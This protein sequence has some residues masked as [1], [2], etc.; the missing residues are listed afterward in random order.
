MP[1]SVVI[2]KD[3]AEYQPKIVGGLT[4]RTLVCIIG[5]LGVSILAGVYLY[6]VLGLNVADNAWL[7]YMVSLPFWLCG[8]IKPKGM[9]FEEFAS[10]W[11]RHQ[12]ADGRLPYIP[13]MI[14]IGYVEKRTRKKVQKYDSIYRKFTRSRGI[15]AYSPRLG[16]VPSAS[17]DTRRW[18]A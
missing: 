4:G 11:W 5:A 3:V 16:M 15:E 14:K 10:L 6:F 18:S 12:T 7:I 2:H 13:S 17:G 1:L 9:K 8:F